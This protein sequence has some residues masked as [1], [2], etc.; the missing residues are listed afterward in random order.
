MLEL[1]AM[2][3][4]APLSDLSRRFLTNRTGNFALNMALAMFP[5]M[6]AV[7]LAIDYNAMSQARSDLQNYLDSAVL[8][9][10]APDVKDRK[11]AGAEFL[12]ASVEGTTTSSEARP[13]PPVSRRSSLSSATP[14]S[15]MSAMM[16]RSLLPLC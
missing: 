14:S 2:S 9:A 4:A 1:P 7:G 5:I 3:A 16:S 6:A 13:P 10:A 15:A 11:G 12:K 8:A